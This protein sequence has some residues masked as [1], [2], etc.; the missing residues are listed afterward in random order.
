MTMTST[1]PFNSAVFRASRAVWAALCTLACLLGLPGQAQ[2]NYSE[3]FTGC[4]AATC[5]NWSIVGGYAASLSPNDPFGEGYSPC[6]GGNPAAKTNLWSSAT[7]T[8]LTSTASVG[9]SN[10]VL[11]TLSFVYKVIDYPDGATTP[12]G[13]AEISAWYSET[14]ASGPWTQIGTSFTNTA[15]GT[16]IAS[17]SFSFTPSNGSPVFIQIRGL[18]LLPDFDG[19]WLVIDDISVIQGAGTDCNATPSPG[20]TLSSVASVCPGGSIN[21]S[22]QNPT[23]GDGVSYQWQR[24]TGSG[25]TD[26]GTNSP[27]QTVSQTV[28]TDYRCVVTCAFAT[29]ADGTSNPV[30]VGLNSY[31]ACYCTTVN[32]TASIEPISL[33]QFA[34][35]NNSSA[36][37]V[38]S[39]GALEDF[40]SITGNINAGQTY[41]MTLS[42]NTDGAFTTFFTAFFDFDQ[43]GSFESSFP[44]GSITNT[45]CVATVSGNITIPVLAPGGLSRMRIVKNYLTSPTDPCGTYAFGQAEDYLVN[46]TAAPVCNGDPTPGNTLATVAVACPSVNFTLS[47]QNPPTTLLNSYQWE[48]ADDAGFTVNVQTLGTAATQVTSQTSAKYY[49][50]LVTCDN[51]SESEY[52][53]ALFVPMGDACVC[54]TYCT[55]SN[56]AD[57]ACITLVE[58]NTLNNATPGCVAFPGYSLQ[59]G[60]TSLQRG[61]S[62]S[63]RVDV[64]ADVYGGGIVSAW[65]DWD[66]NGTFAPTEWFQPYTAG[67]TGT[68]TVPV[69][70]TA[71]LGTIRMRVRSRGQGNPNGA[72]DACTTMGSGETEDYCVTITP[73]P[74]CVP[75]SGLAA[76]LASSTSATITWNVVSNATDYEVELRLSG[77]PGS[78]GEVF[79]GTTS[80]TSILATGLTL[81]QTYQV[82]VRADCDVDGF[83]TWTGPVAYLHDYCAAG[84]DNAFPANNA[85]VLDVT[86]AGVSAGAPPGNQIPY[87]NLTSNIGAMA[88][89]GTYSF[90]ITREIAYT[91]DQFLIWVDWNDDIDFNDPGELVH[92]SPIGLGGGV[93]NATVTCPNG[94]AAGNK[95][96][97]IR[98]QYVDPP[99][100]WLANN[101]PCG[102]SSFGQVLDFTMNVCAPMAATTI[103]NDDCGTGTFSIG[104]SVTALGTGPNPRISYSVNG[105]PVQFLNTPSAGPYTLDNGGAGFAQGAQ[106]TVGLDNGSL[107]V[108]SLGDH[109]GSCPIT[110]NCPNVYTL[111]AAHCYRASDPRTWTFES[112]DPLQTVRIT[113]SQG[114][115]DTDDN[116]IFRDGPGGNQIDQ[117]IGPF[118]LTGFSVTSTGTTLFMEIVSDATGNCF[119]GACSTPWLFSVQCTPDCTPPSASAGSVVQNCA[120]G[121]YQVPVTINSTED[122]FPVDVQ[123][124]INGSPAGTISVA[125]GATENIPAGGVPFGSTLNINVLH[126]SNPLCNLTNVGGTFNPSNTC[127]PSNDECANAISLPVSLPNTC[128]LGGGTLGTTNFATYSTPA[129]ACNTGAGTIRDV[130]YTFNTGTVTS[131]MFIYLTNLT[132]TGLALQLYSGSCGT[133]TSI[134]CLTNATLINFTGFTANTNY[135][136]RVISNTGTGVSGSFRIC[137]QASPTCGGYSGTPTITNNSS[138]TA[139]YNFTAPVGNYIVEYGPSSGWTPGTGATANPPG[140]IVTTSILTGTAGVAQ[141]TCL[142]PAT[143]YRVFVRRDCGGGNYGMNYGIA[144]T[145]FTTLAAPAAPTAMAHAT[146]LGTPIPVVDNS[147]GT[148]ANTLNRT[149]AISGV[150]GTQLGV[151]VVLASVELIMTHTWNSDLFVRLQS[152][153]GCT[154]TLIA[155]RGGSGDNFGVLGT[156]PAQPL[157]LQDGAAALSTM[158]GNNVVGPFEPENRLSSFTGN[159]NGNWVIRVCDAFTGDVGNL[160]YVKLNF[161]DCVGP[162]ATRTAVSACPGG[163]N[164]N[165]NVTSMG[166]ATGY[167]IT[168]NINGSTVAVTG[169]GTYSAGPF[170]SGSNVILTL[171]HNSNPTCNLTLAPVSFLC[172]DACEFAIPLTVGYTCNFTAGTSVGATQSLP[173]STCSDFTSSAANDVWYSFVALTNT[174]RVTVAGGPG[175]DAIVEARSGACNGT[176]VACVDLTVGGQTEVLNLTGLTI[177]Q[178]YLVRVYGWAGGTGTFNICVQAADCNGVYG[179][180][181][182]PGSTCDDGNP[183]TVLDTYGVSNCVCAGIP[184]TTD[185]ALDFTMDSGSSMNWE[186]LQDG[187]NAVVQTGSTILGPTSL[188]VST[189][190]PN[191]CY[192]L[193]VTDAQ[194]D[195][196]TGGGYVL[197]LA[198]GSGPYTRVVDNRENYAGV[199][200]SQISGPPVTS[201]AFCIPLGTDRLIYTSC[202][203]MDWRLSCN[204]E[205]VVATD[206]PAVTAQYNVTNS[207]SGYEMWW[208]APNGGYSFRRVQYHSTPNGLAASATR[209]CHFRPNSWTGNAL[210]QD[211]L[212]NV[213]VRSIVAGTPAPW[214]PACRFM[215]SEAGAACPR[216]QLMDLPDS[217]YLSCGQSRPANSTSSAAFVHARPV[218]RMNGSCQWVNANRYQFRFRIVGEGINVVKTSATNQYWVNTVGLVCGKTY[219]VDVRASFDN[220][221][222]WCAPGGT[223][224][225]DPAWGVSCNLTTNPCAPA[226]GGN[227]NMAAEGAAAGLKMYPNPN[228]GDQLLLS[229]DGIE[230][231]VATVSVDI[232]DAFGKRAIARTL[233]VSDDG[234]VNSVLELNGSLAAG[235]YTVSIT[236]GERQFNE[237]L[238]IQP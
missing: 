45:A 126:A 232:Y 24:N 3:G 43:N 37:P 85:R 57:G 41:S 227:Q 189:C 76:T 71:T 119:D 120:T 88:P 191:G 103:I 44:I 86:G 188:T 1:N 34:D 39:G 136:L 152:P 113:F 234:F 55:T 174:H 131:P 25:W 144:G 148:P 92:T 233:P 216:T 21:L 102:N 171:V 134:G 195:G 196:I 47:L 125:V 8:T 215:L 82:Y 50:C 133:L 223:G 32:F 141:L 9:T 104:V 147:C 38:G 95:R 206:N 61:V 20:N 204:G 231:G 31:L 230:Q 168:N 10:G 65:F 62:Y 185:L 128:G 237:R 210:Q 98:R 156:C 115:L 181:A 169:A 79:V 165:V 36:C 83:S 14:S 205:Y 177:G 13:E 59:S 138:Y 157:R 150:G 175:F 186:L 64:N 214:G 183:N 200:P 40:T 117:V 2:I 221:A 208:Y 27:T 123:W 166:S 225:T 96:M 201:N 213:K 146:C 224:I 160:H 67:L 135:Y 29:P 11:A 87:V 116:I 91:F 19:F 207:T 74:A 108:V 12:A 217:P 73:E 7:S 178:T 184:C 238:V 54:G 137:V 70:L 80:S 167:T 35:I 46:V 63:L 121:T 218:R 49:R 155:G 222:T 192:N 172:N 228:R 149:L 202:D 28:A 209:A 187:T 197:R 94:T 235:L 220:G 100:G 129:A 18:N 112:S 23:S 226:Q 170:P 93:Y 122:G 106:V 118:D 78:G 190:L 72:T 130:W 173:A 48:S 199:T 193:R 111:P 75:P 26:F 110:I 4:D 219:V 77:S 198:S 114:C 81:G 84:A 42:G 139:Q 180:S 6:T 161:V 176:S 105:G 158:T 236:A 60:T 16:C 52:S 51:T 33:V 99:G 90:A 182:I 127:P 151:D 69:P 97:R 153:D 107:C 163:F 68:V 15:T 194:G 58:I 142:T 143:G 203:K 5:N 211:V 124:L 56:F 66:N 140:Q 159:P 30:S 162:A 101:T 109:Y 154:R 229:L 22:L 212:Y 17:P 132:S 89:G 145:V 164:V 53:N 179:G